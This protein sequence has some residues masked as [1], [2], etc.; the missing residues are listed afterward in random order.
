MRS[1]RIN[2]MEGQINRRQFLKVLGAT[3]GSLSLG[4]WALAVEKEIYPAE[5]INWICPYKAGAG[6]DLTARVL[7]PYLT[8]YFR[9]ISPGAK[10]GEIVVKNMTAGGG[11]KA[12]STVYQAEPNGYTIGDFNI[13][14][15]SN[16]IVSPTKLDFDILKF[17]WLFRTGVTTRIMIA[18]KKGFSSWSEMVEASKKETLKWAVG[19]FGGGSHVESIIVKEATKT[20]ARLINFGGAAEQV[21]AVLRGDVHMTL[22]SEDSAKHLVE[23]KEVNVL[24]SFTEE[25]LYPGVPTI[26]EIGYPH[27]PVYLGNHRLVIGPPGL[28]QNIQKLIMGAAEKVMTD[29]ELIALMRQGGFPA[30]PLYG[31]EVVDLVKSYIKFYQDMAATLKKYLSP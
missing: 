7:S 29:P 15:I 23:A 25:P 2:I 12:Y 31:N 16:M 11:I 8:K 6:F 17:T 3:G 20:N 18:N 9:V 30:N 5:K 13:G 22:L 1:I 28:P 21:N 24:V 14:F 27:L 10:G 19:A 26:K 4:K